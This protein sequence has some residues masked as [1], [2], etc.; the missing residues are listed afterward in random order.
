MEEFTIPPNLLSLR[1]LTLLAS[2]AQIV[3]AN[4][5]L[6]VV[7]TSGGLDVGAASEVASVDPETGM[8]AAG[9]GFDGFAHFWLGCL[10]VC[11]Y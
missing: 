6:M 3:L 4:N 5:L 8:A 9:D 11:S 10:F 1:L 7:R 2:P